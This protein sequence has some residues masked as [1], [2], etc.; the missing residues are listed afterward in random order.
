MTYPLFDLSGKRVLVTGS[1]QGIGL[2]LAKGLADHGME[3]SS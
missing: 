2:A 1:S 3:P